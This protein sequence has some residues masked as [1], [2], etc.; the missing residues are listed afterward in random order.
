MAGEPLHRYRAAVGV[1]VTPP[2]VLATSISLTIFVKAEKQTSHKS[3]HWF[4]CLVLLAFFFP[5]PRYRA[6]LN[7]TVFYVHHNLATNSPHA[8]LEIWLTSVFNLKGKYQKKLYHL[9]I[10]ECNFFPI[11]KMICSHFQHPVL[12]DVISMRKSRSCG[13]RLFTDQLRTI[14]GLCMFV[15]LSFFKCTN[16][17]Q[18]Q[19]CLRWLWTRF[20]SHFVSHY[21]LWYYMAP[22]TILCLDKVVKTILLPHSC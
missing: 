20:V 13:S 6:E 7:L 15:C 19:Q 1:L 10:N 11:W 8:M 18:T 3:F 21:I 22:D 14:P 17:L 2:E 16:H 9:Q 12:V 4:W 5:T